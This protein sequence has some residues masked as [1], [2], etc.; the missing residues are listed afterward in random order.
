MVHLSHTE[1][2]LIDQL[3]DGLEEAIVSSPEIDV[4]FANKTKIQKLL[5]LAIQEYDIPITYSWYLAGAVIPNRSIGPN[6]MD[7]F[8]EGPSTPATPSATSISQPDTDTEP[9]SDSPAID[10]ILF[11]G[12][13]DT[14]DADKAAQDL[15]TYVSH[16][17][18]VAFFKQEI[19]TVWH[20]ETMRFLQN[21]YQEMAPDEYRLLYIESTHL[22][23]HLADLL[24]TLQH[25]IEDDA[26]ARSVAA[27]R[28][29]IELSISDLH[30]Y[31][32]RDETFTRVFH[33]VLEGT[34]IIEDI[35]LMLEQAPDS[36]YTERHL[37]IVAE[38]KE[39]FF[40]YVWKYP[41]LLISQQTATGPHADALRTE[42][43]N[44]FDTF[45]QQVLDR[46]IK[47]A[48]T[49]T[50]L[51]LIPGPDDYPPITDDEV[52]QT[53]SDLSAEYLE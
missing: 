44:V 23:T 16:D 21:F 18:L 34:N 11:T 14:N 5:Y 48:S 17:Q 2:T 33:T 26:P 43:G 1:L 4:E 24:E 36:N 35:I 29:A 37:E 47:L 27:I 38:V 40:Y 19:P 51:G 9:V 32:R 42:H 53:L 41:C 12:N 20:Q 6:S 13:D 10:P 8:V 52:A 28:E 3:L 50:S 30:Y 15:G 25:H 45:E 39:F 7:D 46:K 22:R 31:L 49:A